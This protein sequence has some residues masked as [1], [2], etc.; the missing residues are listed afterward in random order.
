[1]GFD[2][3]AISFDGVR[4]PADALLGELN[5][6]FYSIMDTFQNERIVI[7]G[8][9]A[10]E[11]ARAIE[12]T[13]DYVKTRRAFGGS[14]WDQQAVRQ[15]LALLATK[16]AAA[17]QL[18]YAAAQLAETGADCVREVSMVKALSPE[19]LHEVV[20]GCLQLH[21]G[22]G[23]MRGTTIERMVRDAR[24]LTIGGGATEVMLEEV[25]KRM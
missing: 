24:V 8:I 15:K 12:I 25:A 17:R 3:G 19:V 14:L 22:S 18:A 5:R 20:H 10:G 6:G 11:S 16:A 9:C 13:V 2:T 7:A 21:G 4:V 23:Y 1:M